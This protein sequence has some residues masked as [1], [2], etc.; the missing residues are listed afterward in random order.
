M[1]RTLFYTIFFLCFAL[2]ISS[3]EKTPS[4]FDK[5]VKKTLDVAEKTVTTIADAGAKLVYPS[6][7]SI[8]RDYNKLNELLLS[9]RFHRAPEK[10][11]LNPKSQPLAQLIYDNNPKQLE[12]Y[13]QKHNV[14]I[15]RIF[16]TGSCGA[17]GANFEMSLLEYSL[18]IPSAHA[19]KVLLDNGADPNR[20]VSLGGSMSD[21]RYP[22]EIALQTT[23]SD[24]RC[25]YSFVEDL[26]KAGADPNIFPSLP[27]AVKE[28]KGKDI[29][30]LLSYGANIDEK[31]ANG[32]TALFYA[33]EKYQ[34]KTANL[35]VEKG[36][37]IKTMNQEG[38]TLSFLI[39]KQLNELPRKNS[40]P[41][42]WDPLHV[43]I[44]QALTYIDNMQPL[45]KALQTSG[46][47]F[48]YTKDPRLNPRTVEYFDVTTTQ[49]QH[50]LFV[51]MLIIDNKVDSLRQYLERNHLSVDMYLGQDKNCTGST[52]L[53]HAIM[54][55]AKEVFMM[56]IEMGADINKNAIHPD[57]NR[58]GYKIRKNHLMVALSSPKM[59]Y[60]EKLLD[61]GANF[62]DIGIVDVV[63]VGSDESIKKNIALWLEKGADINAKDR[64]TGRTAIYYAI[65]RCDVMYNTAV[66]LV[67]QGADLTVKD[68][69]N[70]TPVEYLQTRLDKMYFPENTMYTYQFSEL[71]VLIQ[72]LQAKGFDLYYSTKEEQPT[73]IR[74][75]NK[76][77][78]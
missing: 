15:N 68:N 28:A 8:G 53:S 52:L 31:D 54:T 58:Q 66:F 59:F 26:L 50:S 4:L 23:P 25:T 65:D 17:Y 56:L 30:W 39:Q 70:Q 73:L 77:R 2:S 67:D 9:S 41:T 51:S 48:Y 45:F 14:D 61:A 69:N 32:K 47:K 60:T 10:L 24:P 11:R 78:N 63:R 29:N 37:D 64:G 3:Q 22:L 38:Q 13:L 74:D 18:L 33:V 16:I 55:D 71:E 57:I 20:K 1:K 19:V 43:Y 21:F 46:S 76:K 6:S 5:A 7:D 42:I 72:R 12:E 27:Y 34:P 40:T 35:L 75:R 36:A 49:G 44:K 62:S